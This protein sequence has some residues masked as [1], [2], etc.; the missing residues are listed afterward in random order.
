MIVV[1]IDKAKVI[2]HEI[3]RAARSSEFAP[4]DDAIAKQIPGEAQGA[5]EQR[6]II[7]EKYAEI[8]TKLDQCEKVEELTN[9]VVDLKNI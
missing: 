6:Q 5:E 3:R 2:A 1:N 9:I 7:R 4:Y 8:Q